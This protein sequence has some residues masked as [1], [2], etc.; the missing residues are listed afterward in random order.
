MCGS[1]QEPIIRLFF[2]NYAPITR[3]HKLLIRDV[4]KS[5]T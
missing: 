3:C 5:G 2:N 1:L 4:I